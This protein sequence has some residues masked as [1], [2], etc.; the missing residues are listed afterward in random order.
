MRR[1]SRFVPRT[2]SDCLALLYYID[3]LKQRHSVKL[4]EGCLTNASHPLTVYASR[5]QLSDMD[6]LSISCWNND[7]GLPEDLLSDS[8]RLTKNVDTNIF[9]PS[10]PIF[11]VTVLG[12]PGNLFVTAVYIRNMT[13][14][15]YMFGLAIADTAVCIC[16]TVLTS[17]RID[18]VTLNFVLFIT[19]MAINLSLYLLAFVSVERFMAVCRP[20]KFDIS[21]VRAKVVSCIMT[22]ATAAGATALAEARRRNYELLVR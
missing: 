21:A 1:T 9:I 6:S 3:I 15:I 10:L 2:V 14:S 13:T 11:L 16:G 7:I 4:L 20:H 17:V 5:Q 19:D 12:L 22:V 8:A 18:Y